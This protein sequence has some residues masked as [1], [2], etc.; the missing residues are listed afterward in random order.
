MVVLCLVLVVVVFSVFGSG[1][2]TFAGVTI[3]SCFLL[4][5]DIF[6][7]LQLPIVSYITVVCVLVVLSEVFGVPRFH[8]LLKYLCFYNFRGRHVVVLVVIVLAGSAVGVGVFIFVGLLHLGDAIF[9]V[10]LRR[11]FSVRCFC[12]RGGGFIFC[13]FY[14]PLV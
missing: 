4:V 1:V 9:V 14:W 8:F 2:T 11:Y 12:W 13:L 3:F 5:C 10:G 6:G 7:C